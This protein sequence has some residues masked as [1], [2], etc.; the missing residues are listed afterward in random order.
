MAWRLGFGKID[1]E[2]CPTVGDF[3]PNPEV[4][5]DLQ[6]INQAQFIVLSDRLDALMEHLGLQ[7]KAIPPDHNWKTE[8]KP[9][10]GRTVAFV[11][12]FRGPKVNIKKS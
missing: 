11:D 8:V 12:G 1:F 9:K 5:I 4:R 3:L 7:F 6:P 2:D 10:E